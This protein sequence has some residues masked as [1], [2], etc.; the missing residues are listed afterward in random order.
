MIVLTIR[1]LI[2]L[3]KGA[4]MK[5]IPNKTEQLFVRVDKYTAELIDLVAEKE[6]VTRSK[7]LYDM[8][9]DRISAGMTRDGKGR[10]YYSV[11]IDMIKA[12]KVGK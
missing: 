7:Y 10:S 1:E 5:G 12:L 8:I 11:V 4:N 9:R 2:N 6:G 3:G